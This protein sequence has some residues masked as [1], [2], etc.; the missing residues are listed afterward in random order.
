MKN[1]LNTQ[2]A[3]LEYP[4]Q[5]LLLQIIKKSKITEISIVSFQI[6]NFRLEHSLKVLEI[7][8]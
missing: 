8:N 3:S 1:K 2:Y 7:I 6:F 4:K 5:L